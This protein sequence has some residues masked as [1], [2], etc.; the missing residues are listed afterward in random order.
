LTDNGA[1]YYRSNDTFPTSEAALLA[2]KADL[3]LRAIPVRYAQWDDW[4][5]VNE[6]G[7]KVRRIRTKFLTQVNS[8]ST[9]LMHACI[10]AHTSSP[11]AF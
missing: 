10:S 1:Y 3:D 2:V 5:Y 7:D 9:Q 8:N 4:W 6:G 11:R